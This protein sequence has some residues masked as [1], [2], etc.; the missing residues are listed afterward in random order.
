MLVEDHTIVREGVRL[1]LQQ[2]PMLEVV[3]E[4]ADGEEALRLLEELQPEVV[5]MDV[6]LPGMNGI[7]TTRLIKASHPQIHVLILSSY[8]PDH[9]IFPLLDAGISGYLLKNTTGSELIRA[10]RTV[11]MG[12]MVL[13]PQIAGKVVQRL[14]RHKTPYRSNEMIEGLSEREIEVLHAV[15]QGKSNKEIGESLSISPNT[16]QVHLSN[17]FSKLGVNDRTEAAAYA[18]RQGWI[19]LS[20]DE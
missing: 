1:L 3:G 20:A 8:A 16:V 15:A 9:F 18:I 14:T 2:T 5:V 6:R 19:N 4:A 12:E 10:I 17:I 13:D 11:H 7:Q